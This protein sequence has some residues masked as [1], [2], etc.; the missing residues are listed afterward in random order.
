[1]RTIAVLSALLALF[2]PAGVRAA[3]A[4]KK[5]ISTLIVTGDDVDAHPWRQTTPALRKILEDTKKFKVVVCE[6]IRILESKEALKGYD[7]IVMNYY[8]AHN[9][10][11]LGDAGKE[12]LLDFVKSGKGFVPFHLSSASFKDWDEFHKLVGRWW[13]MGTSGHGPRGKFKVRIADKDDPITKGLSDFE[14]DDE[15]YA[16]LLGESPIHILAT[17]DSDFSQ[18][19]EPLAFTLSY[20]QGRVFHH[21]FG[22]D[23]KAVEQPTEVAKLFARGCEWAA[24]GKVE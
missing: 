4:G 12:N 1:M 20:G 10:N 3:E 19:T 18:K 11:P 7:L 23:A 8:N 9:P 21:A 24:T 15:L 2:L 5:T 17:A 13:K 16:K 22:H 6:D 14:A